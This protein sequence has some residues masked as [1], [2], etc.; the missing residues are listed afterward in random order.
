MHPLAVFYLLMFFYILSWKKRV[1]K[2]I[3]IELCQEAIAD[4]KA[5]AQLNSKYHFLAPI[6]FFAFTE[7]Y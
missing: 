2:V 3:G 1:K 7:L 5:N 6:F 4:A